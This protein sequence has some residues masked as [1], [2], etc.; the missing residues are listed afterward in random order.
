MNQRTYFNLFCLFLLISIVFASAQKSD[1]IC[2]KNDSGE[3]D[4]YPRVFL[5]TNEFQII[6]EGQ[7]VPPGLHVRLNMETGV[8]EAKLRD[9]NVVDEEGLIAVAVDSKESENRKSDVYVQRN[10]ESQKSRLTAV[11]IDAFGDLLS[12]LGGNSTVDEIMSVLELLEDTVHEVD[13]GYEFIKSDTAA[14]IVINLLSHKISKVRQLAV[15]VF[16]SA[17][18]N[19]PSVSALA[20]SDHDIY[21][22]ILKRM[23][24][25]QDLKTLGRV[26]YAYS[27]LIRSTNSVYMNL[28]K[29]SQGLKPLYDLYLRLDNLKFDEQDVSA[30]KS[31]KGKIW[32]LI[33]DVFDDDMV[34]EGIQVDDSSNPI[35]LD[36]K[37]FVDDVVDGFGWDNW[38]VLMQESENSGFAKEALQAKQKMRSFISGFYKNASWRDRHKFI[39][40]PVTRNMKLRNRQIEPPPSENSKNLSPN[41]RVS[42]T[43]KISNLSPAI[44]KPSSTNKPKKQSALAQSRTKQTRAL[45]S[46]SQQVA[47]SPT[48]NQH[49]SSTSSLSNDNSDEAA[50]VS[51][52]L[53]TFPRNIIVRIVKFFITLETNESNDKK[54][55]KTKSMN[56]LSLV[57]REWY[58]AVSNLIWSNAKLK[59]RNYTRFSSFLKI[60]LES[61]QSINQT[62]PFT[63]SS[64]ITE[65]N[66]ESNEI[67]NHQQ[68]PHTNECLNWEYSWCSYIR[69][70]SI[71]F[72][73]GWP[74]SVT[75]I[76]GLLAIAFPK[77]IKLEII[78]FNELNSR[79]FGLL[80]MWCPNLKSMG[81]VGTNAPYG[82][83]G[84]SSD[85]DTLCINFEGEKVLRGIEI[86]DL[87][88]VR[89]KEI[90]RALYGEI[91]DHTIR[92]F[93]SRLTSF[94]LALV[95]WNNFSGPLEFVSNLRYLDLSR[96]FA[97]IDDNDQSIVSLI[98]TLSQSPML[99]GLWLST[100]GGCH[101]SKSNESNSAMS[102]PTP[103]PGLFESIRELCPELRI[104]GVRPRTETR[105]K[106]ILTVFL[107]DAIGAQLERIATQT[108][109]IG[110]EGLQA[111]MKYATGLK[112]LLLDATYDS[113]LLA[114]FNVVGQNGRKPASKIRY[115]VNLDA[116]MMKGFISELIQFLSVR[117]K[118]LESLSLYNFR[119]LMSDS[120][121]VKIVKNLPN[122][123]RIDV[124][125]SRLSG[126]VC[127]LPS[128]SM[129][130]VDKDGPVITWDKHGR[131]ILVVKLFTPLS[132][133]H[134]VP[135]RTKNLNTDGNLPPRIS[136][137]T[138]LPRITTPE[139]KGAC[140][141]VESG[142]CWNIMLSS[143]P[144][145]E[146][147]NV[148]EIEEIEK[149][150]AD[151]VEDVEMDFFNGYKVYNAEIFE[152]EIFYDVRG[153]E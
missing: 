4:C 121:L 141:T 46:R 95:R 74:K 143:C 10:K 67:C 29:H 111:L 58:A 125:G 128:P 34:P 36:N 91:D 147:V 130:K 103:P 151:D 139:L 31:M 63:H 12:K 65:N 50:I 26:L 30:I 85:E 88:L 39:K 86:G 6:K 37:L 42:V 110:V 104:L 84:R 15:T 28:R 41:P 80:G 77:L 11:Q 78:G 136:T 13:Y 57:S 60:L 101:P 150:T 8:R 135:V 106:D 19:N 22:V 62:S 107:N 149:E 25:E 75:V 123:I 92:L 152:R 134:K 2:V 1:E 51:I 137:R 20:I 99:R 129:M 142:S 117:G 35:V 47:D 89:S 108:E 48:T 146:V 131:A 64:I 116:P 53:I 93:F 118:Q 7:Q 100:S 144:N 72:A 148:L 27:S 102:L 49:E 140:D 76:V 21:N 97:T 71:A 59:F 5:P 133:Y 115:S 126:E 153:S 24:S 43:D 124:R 38:C 98:A 90:E 18:S 109:M 73:P 83:P 69:N 119:G 55:Y 114:G 66:S 44:H 70:I 113:N 14:T 94:R 9:D 56:T 145:L 82:H 40:Y 138:H 68:L 33:E 32:T 3:V 45:R 105:K 61:R 120:L 52:N 122:L 79:A 132:Q 87:D 54:P 81:I 16:G 17:F 96:P 127:F 112:H 23:Q